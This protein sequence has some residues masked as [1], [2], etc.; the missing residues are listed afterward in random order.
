LGGEESSVKALD[1]RGR[2]GFTLIEI[3]VVVIIIAALAGM[4]VPRLWPISDDAKRSIAK[5]DIAS[6]STA[7]RMFRFHC[8]RFPTDAEGLG[9]LLTQPASLPAWRGPYLEKKP[10]DPWKR[11]YQYRCPGTHNQTGFDMWSL[12]P[13]EQKAD[14]DVTNWED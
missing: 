1:R 8:D 6:I 10:L 11:Q 7:V 5:G 2:S 4:V 3:M 9:A 13:D 12:G 14:D